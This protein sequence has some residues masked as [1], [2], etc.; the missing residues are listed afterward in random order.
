MEAKRIPNNDFMNYYL[1]QVL[2]SVC[3]LL[4]LV[5]GSAARQ[6]IHFVAHTSLMQQEEVRLSSASIGKPPSREERKELT[7]R[8]DK[9]P[10]T[11][12]MFNNPDGIPVLIKEAKVKGV[13]RDEQYWSTDGETALSDYAM[14]AR[15]TLENTTTRNAKLVCLK[16]SDAD[17]KQVFYVNYVVERR[18][19]ALV[20]IQLMTLTGNPSGLSVELNGVL[21]EDD[22]VW[23][24]YLFPHKGAK[25]TGS[26]ADAANAKAEVDTRPKLQNRPQPIYTEAAR[27]NKVQGSVRLRIQVG[28]DGSV[29]QVRVTNPLPDGLTEEAIRTAYQLKFSPATKGGAAVEYWSVMTIEFNLK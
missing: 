3:I 18:K 4:L 28:A 23:G 20:F 10:V 15:L 2:K 14:W 16:F 25:Q 21:F 17:A 6:G 5:T 13:R 26:P 12:I 1:S 11:P 29:K 22:S 24:N 8:L 27:A 9:N 19:T 7:E